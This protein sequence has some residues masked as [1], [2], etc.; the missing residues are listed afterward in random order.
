MQRVY[1]LDHDG[2]TGGDQADGG[3]T[4][5]S[6]ELASEVVVHSPN[7]PRPAIHSPVLLS[8]SSCANST[9]GDN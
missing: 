1:D 9:M 7:L 3:I 4:Q 8:F 6:G 5:V 2:H